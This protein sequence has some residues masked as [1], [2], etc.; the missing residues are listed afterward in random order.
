MDLSQ[1]QRYPAVLGL[2]LLAER[3]RR[4]LRF[5]QRDRA[6]GKISVRPHQYTKAR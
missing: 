4:S 2:L 3:D 5:S 1:G 6:T